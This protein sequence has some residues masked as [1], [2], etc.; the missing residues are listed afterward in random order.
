[1]HRQEWGEKQRRC[2]YSQFMKVRGELTFAHLCETLFQHS[3]LKTQKSLIFSLKRAYVISNKR[4]S[5]RSRLMEKMRLFWWFLPTMIW[6][7]FIDRLSKNVTDPWAKISSA[8]SSFTKPNAK[9][10]Q[11]QDVNWQGILRDV[12]AERSAENE[13]FAIRSQGC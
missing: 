7:L 12:E 3:G 8:D 2:S 11:R 5:L 9:S 4:C 6:L 10:S 1:M 13:R